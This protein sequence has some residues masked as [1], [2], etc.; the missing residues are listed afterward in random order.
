MLCFI[1]LIWS[2]SLLL[3][4]LKEAEVPFGSLTFKSKAALERVVPF[5]AEFLQGFHML[6]HFIDPL[7]ISRHTEFGITSG[8]KNGGINS[9]ALSTNLLAVVCNSS[10]VDGF[11]LDIQAAVHGNLRQCHRAAAGDEENA[12]DEL[13]VAPQSHV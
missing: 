10:S 12:E 6:H 9:A 4:L 2:S 11:V 7:F 13:C 8:H 5:L 3:L 1:S